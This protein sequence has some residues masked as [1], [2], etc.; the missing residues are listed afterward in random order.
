MAGKH[1][2]SLL[3]PVARGL[4][5]IGDRWTLLI[6]R[7]LHAGPA[8]FK[9]LQ[10]GL[11][12]IATNLLA[13]RLRQLRQD[14]LIR[15]REAGSGLRVYELTELGE[16]TDAV[17]FALA[18]FGTRFPPEAEPRRPGN[19][20]AIALPLKKLLQAVVEKDASLLAELWIDGEPF[21]VR[22]AEG[23]VTVRAGAAPEATVSVATAYSRMLAVVDGELPATE[24]GRD[25][26]EVRRAE[27]EDLARF[28][29][30]M[31][32]ALTR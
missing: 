20:R 25:H 6:L 21:R 30:W 22:V 29:E 12:G 2:Y 3:C 31:G 8:R 7:D 19:S 18:E 24:F 23:E 13:A 10:E 1:R 5:R 11:T 32:R 17:I 14:G 16:E 9:D 15:Q 4:D 28:L 26:V 27:P